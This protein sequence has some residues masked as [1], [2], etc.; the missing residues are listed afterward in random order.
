MPLGVE[1]GY[2][3][4]K[5]AHVAAFFALRAGGSIHVR[6][7]VSLAYLADR[8]FLDAYDEPIL[9]DHLVSGEHGPVDATLLSLLNGNLESDDWNAVIAS[10]AN[11]LF[12]LSTPLT[13]D[14]L[15]ALSDAEFNALNDTWKR[16]GHLDHAA[17][18]DHVTTECPEWEHTDQPYAVIPYSRVFK[19]L[20]RRELSVAL[21]EG[22]ASRMALQAAL[23]RTDHKVAHSQA[24]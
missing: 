7:L 3:V 13:E 16:F 19:F 18:A 12:G 24:A 20:G 6:R 4:R 9:F 5:A 21:E 8:A 22:I 23:A 17:L 14:D 11:H 2:N 1:K 15:D 10:Q